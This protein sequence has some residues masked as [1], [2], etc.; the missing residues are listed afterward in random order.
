MLSIFYLFILIISSIFLF[1]S[2]CVKLSS[3]NKNPIFDKYL[4]SDKEYKEEIVT[5][6]ANFDESVLV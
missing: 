2:S 4:L 3:E 1:I 5:Q 6:L